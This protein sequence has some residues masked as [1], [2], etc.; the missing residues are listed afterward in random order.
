VRQE[1]IRQI[2]T[3]FDPV[4]LYNLTVANNQIAATHVFRIQDIFRLYNSVVAQPGNTI[5][6]PGTA[7][8]EGGGIVS[9]NIGNLP[10]GVSVLTAP[11]FVD[12]ARRDYRP[13]AGSRAVDIGNFLTVP[14]QPNYQ[15]EDLF[16]RGHNIDIAGIGVT[17]RTVDAGAF[18]RE[19]YLPL[20]LNP[21][22]DSD[23]NLWQ[24][25]QT[26]E[27]AW[28]GTQN[29]TGPAGSGAAR[30]VIEPLPERA[31]LVAGRGQC[32]HIPLSGTYR[33]NG[34]GRVQ[35]AS[36]IMATRRARLVWELR[37]SDGNFGC[38]SGPPDQTGVL[39]LSSTGT[40]TR[41]GAPALINVNANFNTSL[42]IKLDVL[43]S[44]IGTTTGWFDGITL[45]PAAGA[46]E[47]FRNGFE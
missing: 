5:T 30:V 26:A 6:A 16:G 11:R 44:P 38:D 12:P 36:T 9:D 43:G 41:P 33:L 14:G 23:L 37:F 7:T 1:L 15:F 39:E 17:N 2:G 45:E 25:T 28:D 32:I 42:T 10:G 13:R 20:V 22:F 3:D 46:E 35:P 21:N 40:W 31:P 4:S 27:S 18:E 19:S 47:I 34:F 29:I 24:A 8:F